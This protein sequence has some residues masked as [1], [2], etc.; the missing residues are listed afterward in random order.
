MNKIQSSFPTH[1][2]LRKFEVSRKKEKGYQ[3]EDGTGLLLFE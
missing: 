2:D 1:F 3:E